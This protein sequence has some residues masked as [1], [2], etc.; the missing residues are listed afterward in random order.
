MHV[1]HTLR[2]VSPLY[3]HILPLGA[4]CGL[5]NRSVAGPSDSSIKRVGYATLDCQVLRL[6][7]E[8]AVN[9]EGET[10]MGR[11]V[12]LPPHATSVPSYLIQP[13]V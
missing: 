13:F 2:T 12:L 9:I 7:E 5:T 8:Q 4:S 10:I 11:Q 6:G 1:R 3:L